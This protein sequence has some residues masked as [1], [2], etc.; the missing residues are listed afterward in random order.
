M[1]AARCNEGGSGVPYL[2][3]AEAALKQQ[4]NERECLFKGASIYDVRKTLGISDPPSPFIRIRS[5]VAGP[6]SF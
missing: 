2:E 1:R 5:Y 3:A 4:P 6:S